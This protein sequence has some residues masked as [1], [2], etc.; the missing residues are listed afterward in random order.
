MHYFGVH[1]VF[2]VV[3]EGWA[4]PPNVLE[5]EV[6]SAGAVSSSMLGIGEVVGWHSVFDQAQ[7][8]LS[9]AVELDHVQCYSETSAFLR[10]KSYSIT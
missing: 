1:F 9:R 7:I 3:E 6:K 5:A 8:A 10:Y 4:E 2:S